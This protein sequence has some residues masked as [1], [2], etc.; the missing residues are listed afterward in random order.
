MTTAALRFP[1]LRGLSKDSLPSSVPWSVV[2]PH[3]RQAMRNHDQTLER[4][5]ER[6][7]LS[8][9]ELWMVC[10]DRERVGSLPYGAQVTR[11]EA[12]AWLRSVAGPE[13]RP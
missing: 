6:G 8:P 7:G 12:V 5:A 2:E 4:L 10:H 11:E 9:V 3:S 1:V 13:V